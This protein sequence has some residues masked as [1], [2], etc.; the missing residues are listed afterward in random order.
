MAQHAVVPAPTVSILQPNT[1]QF[2]YEET[3]FT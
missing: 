3:I 1:N 2:L